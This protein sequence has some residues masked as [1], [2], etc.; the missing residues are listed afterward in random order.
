M[1][2]P[3]ISSLACSSIPHYLIPLG[4]LGEDGHFLGHA[5]GGSSLPWTCRT[6]KSK[7]LGPNMFAR[8]MLPWTSLIA[9]SKCN[10]PNELSSLSA[11]GLTYLSNS[12]Y[13]GL[14]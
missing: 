12:C 14:G 6:I 3:R 11:L 2:T 9:K 8:R 4:V 7:F 13:L 5:N 10:R 1:P